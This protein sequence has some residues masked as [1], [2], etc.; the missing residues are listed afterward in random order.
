MKELKKCVKGN[1]IIDISAAIQEYVERNGFSVVREYVG[2]G[3]GRE[4]H[5][6]PQI[7]N[8]RTKRKRTKA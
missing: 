2:H 1:R 6:P 7:P 3:I 4:M 8:Y 5:E